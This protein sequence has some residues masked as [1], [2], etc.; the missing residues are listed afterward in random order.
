MEKEQRITLRNAV[1]N[2]RKL[3]EKEFK[4]QLEGTYNILPDGRIVEDAPGDPI[5]RARL[6]DVIHHYRAGGA[7]ATEAVERTV[8]EA[9]FT[10]LNRFAALKMAERRGL[11]SITQHSDIPHESV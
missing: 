6:Q 3:L 9:A 2:V 4:E 11:L 8:R 5:T 10:V 1:V 7:T